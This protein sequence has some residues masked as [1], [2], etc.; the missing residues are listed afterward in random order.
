MYR[1]I[2]EWEQG[3]REISINKN[4]SINNLIVNLKDEELVGKILTHNSIK[5]YGWEKI[6][7]K[8]CDGDTITL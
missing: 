4:L 6:K 1:I 3:K 2:I 8:L 5:L 7:D